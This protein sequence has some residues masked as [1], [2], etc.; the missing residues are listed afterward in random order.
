MVF[1][2]IDKYSLRI[3]LTIF[4]DFNKLI[5]FFKKIQAKF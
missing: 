5:F 3:F 1:D 4:K 2:Y